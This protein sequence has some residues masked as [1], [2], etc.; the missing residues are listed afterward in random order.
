MPIE[1]LGKEL[2][3]EDEL[4]A[5]VNREVKSDRPKLK[6]K[7]LTY[8]RDVLG[9]IPKAV[10]VRTLSKGG[11]KA[12][13]THDAAQ[14]AVFVMKEN[15]QN[16]KTLKEIKEQNQE[17]LRDAHQKSDQFRKDFETHNQ[18]LKLGVHNNIHVDSDVNVKIVDAQS[19]SQSSS[20]DQVSEKLKDDLAEVIKALSTKH[21]DEKLLDELLDQVYLQYQYR[22]RLREKESV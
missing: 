8:L 13:Y 3:S 5:K 21:R 10:R 11:A 14:C 6:R 7:M 9:L 20:L 22:L 17:F 1:R 12:Y 2:I 4:V 18:S 15:W 19:P 16:N